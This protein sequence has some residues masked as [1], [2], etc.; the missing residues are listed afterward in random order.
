MKMLGLI[1][2]LLTG[3][4]IAG[5]G[6]IV[7][8]IPIDRNVESSVLSHDSFRRFS[9]FGQYHPIL[10][11]SAQWKAYVSSRDSA[12]LFPRYSRWL[13]APLEGKRGLRVSPEIW[14]EAG[15]E[16]G[17]WDGATGIAAGGLRVYGKPFEK[18]WLEL[19]GIAGA[20]NMPG[21]IASVAD[22]T[23]V[24]PGMAKAF[25]GDMATSYLFRGSFSYRP[26]KYLSLTVGHDKRFVGDGYRSLLLSDFGNAYPFLEFRAR[27]WHLEYVNLY[28]WLRDIP[29]TFSDR[30]G[31]SNKFSTTHLLTWKIDESISLSFFETI[32]WQGR[33]TLSDRGFDVNYL[34]PVIFYRPV[35]FAQ[36]SADNALMGLNFAIRPPELVKVYGQFLIDEFLLSEFRAARG[37]WANKYGGQIGLEFT[38]IGPH[39]SYSLQVE[40]NF[41]RPFTYTHGSEKQS[42]THYG[43]PLAH[44]LGSN[45]REYLAIG[46]WEK[47]RWQIKNRLVYADYGRDPDTLNLGGDIYKSYR[48]PT[49]AYGNDIGQGIDHKLL[50]NELQASYLLDSSIGLKAHAS[51]IF[52]NEMIENRSIQTH[53]INLGISTTL[54]NFYRTF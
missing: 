4:A 34:N 16:M 36:G 19:S 47:G 21:Y 49:M 31:E 29:G 10:P 33:D 40:Y 7:Q 27:V 53:W 32:I 11:D 22:S 18:T 14:T 9:T 15:Y 46:G 25:N 3:F 54:G 26:S 50:L 12:M 13:N 39:D 38:D 35:E 24:F 2:A 45:F 42:Y 51:Y 52:R 1:I 44:P 6:Q 28:S 23:R 41:V 17:E 5:N 37:W 43:L 20:F 8:T 30:S 48:G